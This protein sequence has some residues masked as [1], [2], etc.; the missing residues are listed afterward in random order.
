MALERLEGSSQSNFSSA[1]TSIRGTPGLKNSRTHLSQAMRAGFTAEPASIRP[2]QWEQM[3]I[4]FS[5][6][7]A[8]MLKIDV[9]DTG[10]KSLATLLP[11]QLC[12]GEMELFW[13]GT[14]QGAALKTGAYLLQASFYDEN[15]ETG[16]LLQ[17]IV[18]NRLKP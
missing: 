7:S 1:Q 6:N 3:R 18:I 4:Q 5:A 16:R 12:T 11:L 14:V 17:R 10:G 2:D 8:K 13:D 9:L 15:G